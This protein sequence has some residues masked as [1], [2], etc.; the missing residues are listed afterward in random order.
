MGATT[1]FIFL[2]IIAKQIS[3]EIRI[4]FQ[5]ENTS[6]YSGAFKSTEP[7]KIIPFHCTLFLYSICIVTCILFQTRTHFRDF[8]ELKEIEKGNGKT[9][10]FVTLSFLL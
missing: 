5:N 9:Q 1:D 6:V 4:T 10:N 3:R 7:T 8:S 2:F